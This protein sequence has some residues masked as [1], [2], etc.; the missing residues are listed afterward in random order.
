MCIRV[1]TKIDVENCVC[2][3]GSLKSK[4]AVADEVRDVCTAVSLAGVCFGLQSF[5]KRL[6][7]EPQKFKVVFLQMHSLSRACQT[8][9]A[10]ICQ[11]NVLTEQEHCV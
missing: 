10:K 9:G 5:L 4:L 1:L 6:P 7:A 11:F 3:F 2:V 8:H